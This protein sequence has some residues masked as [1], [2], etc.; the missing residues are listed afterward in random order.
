MA[1]EREQASQLILHEVLWECDESSHRFRK[2]QILFNAFHCD[3][4]GDIKERL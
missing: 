3:V 2:G 1:R 4:A